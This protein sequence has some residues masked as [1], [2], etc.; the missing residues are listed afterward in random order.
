MTRTQTRLCYGLAVV[1]WLIVLGLIFLSPPARAESGGE[2]NNAGCNG[3]GNTN[4][5]CNQGGQGGHGGNGGQGGQG[6]NGI[7]VGVGVGIGVG[8]A[9]AS[10]S[11][12]AVSV[13]GASVDSTNLNSNVAKG[14]NASATGGAAGATA[15][16][17]SA[18]SGG[19]TQ[20]VNVTNEGDEFKRQAPAGPSIIANATAPCRVAVGIGGSW[21]AGSAGIT[22]STLDEGCNRRENARLLH[23]LG[24]VTAAKMILCNEPEVAA[25]LPACK[26][27]A[28]TETPSKV[29]AH[30]GYQREAGA[31][32]Y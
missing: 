8:K 12:T 27:L 6:G 19:N 13:A 29:S 21:I 24:E 7:G 14:G 26:T 9:S 17:G 11:A 32:L 5:P 20:N 16:G 4:S 1:L 22:G 15:K 28:P 25:V 30:T 23:N 10:S 3:V 2:G 18:Y 31:S